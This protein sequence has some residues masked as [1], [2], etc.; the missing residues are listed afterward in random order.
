VTAPPSPVTWLVLTYRLPANSGLK[1]VVRRKLTATGAVYPVNAVAALPASPAAERAFRRLRNTIGEG[2]GSAQVLRAEAVEGEPA[3]VAAYNAAREHEY[4]EIIARCGDFVARIEAMTAAGHFCYHDLG[5]KDAELK[6][7]SVRTRTIRAHD[8]LGAANARTALSSLARCRAVLDE[9]AS[10][11]YQ[12][13]AAS[14]TGIGHHG[15]E[16]TTTLHQEIAAE[17]LAGNAEIPPTVPARNGEGWSDMGEACARPRWRRG[18]SEIELLEAL[19]ADAT[20]RAVLERHDVPIAPLSGPAWQRFPVAFDLTAELVAE[21]YSGCG[22]ALHHIE[23]LTGRPAA[24]I[25]TLLRASGVQLRD[26]AAKSPFM[27]RW[28]ESG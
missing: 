28:R 22:L 23:L 7:L 27:R 16:P 3:L 13:D 24:T 9:F 6:R 25:A 12:T 21:L 19:Y 20:V 11:V 14:T 15:H 4:G 26:A 10:R 17:G 5:E 2:D 1:A 18:P 8:A